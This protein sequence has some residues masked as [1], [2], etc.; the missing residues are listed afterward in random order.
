[1]LS[2]GFISKLI[3]LKAFITSLYTHV[4]YKSFSNQF[5][6]LWAQLQLT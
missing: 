5:T 2:Q 6:K 1:M 3:F 4:D